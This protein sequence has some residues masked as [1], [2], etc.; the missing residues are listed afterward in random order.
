MPAVPGS[1]P[2]TLD[3]VAAALALVAVVVLYLLA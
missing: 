1:V 2:M 3:D